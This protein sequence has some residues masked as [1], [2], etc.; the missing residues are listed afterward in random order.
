MGDGVQNQLLLTVCPWSPFCP[1]APAPPV[2]PPGPNCP[3]MPVEPLAPL[4]PCQSTIIMT[5]SFHNFILLFWLYFSAHP[6]PWKPRLS[7][8]P[9]LTIIS[10][11]ITVARGQENPWHVTSVLISTIMKHWYKQNTHWLPR[12]TLF[13]LCTLVSSAAFSALWSSKARRSVVSFATLKKH[14]ILNSLLTFF[15]E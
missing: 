8:V 4:S 6:G 9:W 11:Q 12:G 5:T 1:L 7:F 15:W 10:L 3:G 2:F 13:S 14:F